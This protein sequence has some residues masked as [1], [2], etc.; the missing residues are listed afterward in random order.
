LNVR[1]LAESSGPQRGQIVARESISEDKSQEARFECS[2]HPQPEFMSCF[3]PPR[4]CYKKAGVANYGHTIPTFATELENLRMGV[5]HKRW[6]G[7]HAA[8][9]FLGLLGPANEPRGL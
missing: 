9:N 7:G 6:V 8:T 5:T 1:A 2:K 3:A 4:E